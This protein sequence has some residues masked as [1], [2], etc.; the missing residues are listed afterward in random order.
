MAVAEYLSH[1]SERAE[2][3]SGQTPEYC[4]GLRQTSVVGVGKA[5]SDTLSCIQY[6]TE[7]RVDSRSQSRRRP[8]SEFANTRWGLG[9]GMVETRLDIAR[10]RG[11]FNR[12]CSSFLGSGSDNMGKLFGFEF[13]GL[14]AHHPGPKPPISIKIA[15]AAE[16]KQRHAKDRGRRIGFGC[17]DVQTPL[18][19]F[20]SLF[21][22][23]YT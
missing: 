4:P 13:P 14:L 1:T 8:S 5:S 11:P 17:L 15:T 7:K 12:R 3:R 22:S 18:F 21:A 20:T 6:C 10:G 9:S 16:M 2:S 23:L 19:L